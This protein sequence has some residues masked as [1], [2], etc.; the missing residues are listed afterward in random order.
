MKRK[1]ALECAVHMLLS[2]GAALMVSGCTPRDEGRAL[3]NASGLSTNEVIALLKTGADVNRR[4]SVFSGF[5]PLIVAIRKDKQD[6]VEV[7]IAAGADVNLKDADGKTPVMHALAALEPNI[8]L[9]GTLI[10][11]GADP[12][13]VDRDGYDAFAYARHRKNAS[14][15]VRALDPGDTG[16]R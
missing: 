16:V 15:I 1:L 9:I 7:L 13:I 14:D 3:V 10:S 5:T 8:G 12:R 2:T 4:S 6:V 11:H